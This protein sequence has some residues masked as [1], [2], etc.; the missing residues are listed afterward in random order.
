MSTFRLVW[1]WL[2]AGEDLGLCGP[3]IPTLATLEIWIDDICLTTCC[4]N[5]KHSEQRQHVIGPLSGLADWLVDHWMEIFWQS[6]TPFP[7]ST[8]GRG[9]IPDFK[10]VLNSEDQHTDLA[11]YAQ[12]YGSHCLGQAASDLALPTILFIPEDTQVGIALRPASSLGASCTFSLDRE[13][14]IAWINKNDLDIE[15]QRFVSAI[16]DK[17]NQDPLTVQWAAWLNERWCEVLGRAHDVVERRRQLYG[18]LVADHWQGIEDELGANAKI[19]DGIL[20]DSHQV[21]SADELL[22]LINQVKGLAS[23]TVARPFWSTIQAPAGEGMLPAFER[24]YRKAEHIRQVLN[25]GD[26]PIDFPEVLESLQIGLQKISGPAIAR[27]AFMVADSG[28]SDVA[29]FTSH[30]RFKDILPQR[31]SL[32]SALGGLLASRFQSTPFGGASSDQARW[33]RSQETNAFAAMFLLP[34][35]TLETRRSL[36]RLVEDYGISYSAASWHTENLRQRKLRQ[37]AGVM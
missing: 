13:L 8:P 21:Q 36:E 25:L 32:A 31:F 30:P 22:S 5:T 19:I 27:S 12:W 33:I 34:A 17:A 14:D 16:L 9:R 18:D 35:S 7:K 23:E 3:E 10:E 2:A 15:L 4:D 20:I 1:D 11:A 6:H 37:E 26:D 24:G 28:A 29:L